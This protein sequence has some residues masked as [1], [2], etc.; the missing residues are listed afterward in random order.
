MEAAGIEPDSA[1]CCVQSTSVNSVA[2]NGAKS[3][4]LPAESGRIDHRLGLVV[5]RWHDLPETVRQD[6]LRLACGTAE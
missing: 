3:G 6:I 2:T 5:A 1:T 4:A